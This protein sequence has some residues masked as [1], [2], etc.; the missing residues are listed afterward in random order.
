[1]LLQKTKSFKAISPPSHER[2]KCDKS[3]SIAQLLVSHNVSAGGIPPASQLCS[4]RLQCHWQNQL[5]QHTLFLSSHTEFCHEKQHKSDI[6]HVQYLNLDKGQ[7]TAQSPLLPE[8]NTLFQEDRDSPLQWSTQ[9]LH[10]HTKHLKGKYR[11]S[12]CLLNK[13][14][15]HF[16]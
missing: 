3:S 16:K 9:H 12:F 11:L 5:S 7:V 14:G 10:L 2:H 15:T 8:I 1:M 6:Q 13:S 4:L